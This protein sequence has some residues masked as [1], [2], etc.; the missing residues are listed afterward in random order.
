MVNYW[1]DEAAL[2]FPLTEEG[3]RSGD[4]GIKTH[5]SHHRHPLQQ[6]VP[7]AETERFPPNVTAA[8]T[9]PDTIVCLDSPSAGV[10]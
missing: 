1:Y 2:F 6:Q 10:Q 4:D 3:R 8:G 9:L 5:T 7:N